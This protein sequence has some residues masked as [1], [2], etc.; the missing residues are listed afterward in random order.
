[1]GLRYPR[2]LF[3]RI[4]DKVI[5]EMNEWQNRPLDGVYAAI[6]IDAIVVKIRDGQVANR[7]IYAYES[8]SAWPERKRSSACG[9]EPVVRGRS[10][11]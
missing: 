10:S 9:L 8:G 3:S 4:T 6:F 7:P 1:M 11:G 5:E 2:R